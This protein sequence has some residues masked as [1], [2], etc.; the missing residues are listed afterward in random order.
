MDRKING[1]NADYLK[2][3]AKNVSKELGITHTEALDLIAKDLGYADWYNLINNRK[4]EPLPKAAL[5]SPKVPEPPVLNYRN[6]MTGTIIGQHPNK[7][8]P[9]RRHARVGSL[10]QKLLEE[11]EYHKRAKNTIQDIR[12]TMDTWLGCEYSEAELANAEFN[13]IYY[14]KTN[15]LDWDMPLQKRQAELKRLLRAARSVID[16]SYHDCKP[17]DKLHQ[18]FDLALKALEKWP[19]TVKAPGLNRFKSQVPAGTFVRLDHNKQIG[20]VFNHD[21]ERQVIEGYADGG[22]FLAGRHEVSVLRKQLSISDFKPMRLY[23]PY[24]KWK[25]DDGREVL[26]NRDYCPIWEKSADGSVAVI[27]PDVYVKHEMSEHYYNDRTAP[28]YDNKET[29]E[30]CLEVLR[31]WGVAEKPNVLLEMLPAALVAGDIRLL[32]PKGM[33]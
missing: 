26:F 25:C 29:F 12:I 20:V 27:Q 10:L 28:Y 15:N 30:D 23:L 22:R 4:V 24:G 7:K 17:L 1:H 6:F 16:R 5:R 11:V 31:G 9:I 33:S 21:T 19:T 8:M 18:Q 2:R 13:Q 14:G 32:S 3:K